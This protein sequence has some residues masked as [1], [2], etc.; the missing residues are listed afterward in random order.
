MQVKKD[1]GYNSLSVCFCMPE[2]NLAKVF[3]PSDGQVGLSSLGLALYLATLTISHKP[4]CLLV[5][6]E[7]ASEKYGAEGKQEEQQYVREGR[8]FICIWCLYTRFLL[9]ATVHACSSFEKTMHASD[10][11]SFVHG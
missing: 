7:L 5:G 6:V 8:S 3:F 1:A 9:L 11:S 4:W 2:Y 10:I